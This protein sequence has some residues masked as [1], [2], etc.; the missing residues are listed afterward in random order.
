MRLPIYHGAADLDESGFDGSISSAI[1]HIS[2]R[3]PNQRRAASSFSA[4]LASPV[5][6]LLGAGPRFAVARRML[7]HEAMLCERVSEDM[8]RFALKLDG[9][10]RHL[11]SDEEYASARM[12]LTLLAGSYNINAVR[13]TR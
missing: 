6:L 11:V 13:R 3:K 2:F 9:M 4:S 5:L 1:S 12:A 8:R 10:R 7:V